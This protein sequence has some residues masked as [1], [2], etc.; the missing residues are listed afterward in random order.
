MATLMLA[1]L[2]QFVLEVLPGRENTNFYICTGTNPKPFQ[3]L[4]LK[5]N[6]PII[7]TSTI[8]VNL[9]LFVV[10]MISGHKCA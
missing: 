5:M 6:F 4:N 9:Y 8:S 1:S 7:V 3:D 10:V 2:A